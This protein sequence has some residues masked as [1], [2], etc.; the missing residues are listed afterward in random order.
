MVCQVDIRC[1]APPRDMELE[2][3]V[4]CRAMCTC[5]CYIFLKSTQRLSH[6]VCMC[7]LVGSNRL[8]THQDIAVYSCHAAMVRQLFIY[9]IRVT[10][11]SPCHFNDLHWLVY[12]YLCMCSL[13]SGRRA[14]LHKTRKYGPMSG[15]LGPAGG[16]NSQRCDEVRMQRRC[17]A[18]V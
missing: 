2:A 10:A 7:A 8:Q 14:L 6:T 9:H 18:L 5:A 12:M 1:S 13:Q 16:P 3:C 4:A 11:C 15:L 17:S